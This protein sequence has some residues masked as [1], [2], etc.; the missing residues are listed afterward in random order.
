MADTAPTRMVTIPAIRMSSGPRMSVV[1]VSAFSQGVT[2]T[3]AHRSAGKRLPN[4][5]NRKERLRR[6]YYREGLEE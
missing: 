5:I 1:V 2:T 4:V 6:M 3:A